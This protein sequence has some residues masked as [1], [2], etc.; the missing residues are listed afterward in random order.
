[1]FYLTL[2]HDPPS[3]FLAGTSFK[4][5]FVSSRLA[6]LEKTRQF[7]SAWS[8]TRWYCHVKHAQVNAELTAVLIP[9]VEHDV[10]QELNPGHCQ[11]FSITLEHAPGLLHAGIVALG[12]QASDGGDAL[13]EC[14]ENFSKTGWLWYLAEIGHLC[15]VLLYESDNASWYAGDMQSE[16]SSRH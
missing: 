1:V 12:Q 16:L 3:F 2:A 14:I 9:V 10:P 4:L 13:L 8:P 5:I 7:V 6:L 11:K 15:G